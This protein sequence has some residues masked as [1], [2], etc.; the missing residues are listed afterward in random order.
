MRRGLL[1][2]N[3]KKVFIGSPMKYKLIEHELALYFLPRVY[4]VA[5]LLRD[6]SHQR[7]MPL[8]KQPTAVRYQQIN[9][10][11]LT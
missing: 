2:T 8:L 3:K 6:K 1:L 5:F 11:V 4:S 7:L 9:N 10:F